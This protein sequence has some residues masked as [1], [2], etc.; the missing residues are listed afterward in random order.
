MK[1]LVEDID[2]DDD[3]EL[4]TRR[5]FI[6][7]KNQQ[8]RD[9]YAQN[10]RDWVEVKARIDAMDMDELAEYAAS[11]EGI[12]NRYGAVMMRVSPQEYAQIKLKMR[13]T[14]ARSARELVMKL[15]MSLQ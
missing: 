13:Q 9:D 11:V 7:K 1:S 12:A 3:G 15:L 4:L 14:R 2:C 8:R 10:Q 5:D 6:K